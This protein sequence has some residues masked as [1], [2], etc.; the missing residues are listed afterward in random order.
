MKCFLQVDLVG[1]VWEGFL[2]KVV[3]ELITEGYTILA[4]KDVEGGSSRESFLPPILLPS[5]CAALEGWTH[6]SG[7]HTMHKS[8]R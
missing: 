7:E 3:S 4:G 2:E 6:S 5:V 8:A 1:V